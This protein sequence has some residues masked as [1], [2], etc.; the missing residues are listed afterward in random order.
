VLQKRW[1]LLLLI[2]LSIP[3]NALGQQRPLR[4]DDAELLKTGWIRAEF[5]VEFLQ[6]QRY[7]LSGLRGDLTRLG[8]SSIQ[9]GVGD[10]AEFKIS[11][12]MQDF[13]SVSS[14]TDQPPIP[15]KFAGNS[16]S[17]FGDLILAT[18]LKLA[19]ENGHRPALAFEFGV[20]LPN[21][22]HDSGLG[23][24]ETEFYSSLLFRKS[25]GRIQIL[26][27]AGLA[28]LGSPVL[29]GRQTDP[30]TY[31]VATIVPVKKGVNFV[32]EINGREGPPNRLGNENKS[33]VRAGIQFWT[34]KVRWDL[35]AVAGLTAF[36]PKSGVA[37][38]ATYEFKAFGSK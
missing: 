8:V 38:G 36:D 9:V 37:V 1:L 35:G 7:S 17:D 30:M 19:S 27:N 14:R 28:I 16:T 29:Q 22:K 4:T 10:Y 6:D 21:A 25:F 23:T 20:E 13:L 24:D 11:G 3:W 26:G 12:V 32:A 2:C 5:G 15:P 33:Q 31:G 18:K 34:G